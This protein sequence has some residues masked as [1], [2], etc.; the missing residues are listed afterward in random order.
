MKHHT[1]GQLD[2]AEKVQGRFIHDK[3]DTIKLYVTEKVHVR[4]HAV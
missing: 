4:L 2:M 1:R 3:H